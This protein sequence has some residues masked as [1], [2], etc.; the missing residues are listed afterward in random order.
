M[1]S[2]PAWRIAPN[3]DLLAVAVADVVAAAITSAVAARGVATVAVPGG[4][5]PRTV[6]AQLAARTLPWA[7]TC[8]VLGDDRWVAADHPASNL[9]MIRGILRDGPASAAT[10]VPMVEGPTTLNA[11]AAAAD[12]RLRALAWPLDLMWLGV[13]ADA[14]TASLFPGEDY[15]AAIDPANP[16]R[17]MAVTPAMLPPEAPF[18]RLTMPLSTLVDARALILVATGDDKR[19][20][21]EQALEGAATPVGRVIAA[22]QC[23]VS[24]H[25][26][27]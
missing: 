11:D 13:G 5:T 8:F 10:L 26:A 24:I 18:P 16:R 20:V 27:A 15:A 17:A 3:R 25:W 2:A 1:S 23:P 4:S 12:A 6:F 14:H 7:Q 21:L 22:A 19:T 9:G